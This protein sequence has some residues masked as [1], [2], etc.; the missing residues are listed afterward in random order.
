MP[1][2]FNQVLAQLEF[3]NFRFQSI[4]TVALLSAFP[5]EK[6]STTL[7]GQKNK[8]ISVPPNPSRSLHFQN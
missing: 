3:Y 6:H 7:R 1:V 5:A 2:V 8:R 4:T